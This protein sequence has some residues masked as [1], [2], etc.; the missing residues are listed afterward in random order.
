M[1]RSTRSLLSILKFLGKLQPQTELQLIAQQDE[2]FKVRVVAR[3]SAGLEGWTPQHQPFLSEDNLDFFLEPIGTGP[4]RWSSIDLNGN[5]VLDAF[6]S[7]HRGPPRIERVRRRR[8]SDKNTMI[9]RLVQEVLDLIP[10]T[11]F[12]DIA[13]IRGSGVCRTL[14]YPSLKFAGLAFNLQNPF[15]RQ[16]KARQAL[17]MA[18]DRQ[19][20][21][22]TY[23]QNQGTVIAG[24][25]SPHSWGYDFELEPASL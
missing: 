20:L 19:E 1:F 2:W 9:N 3:G 13:R 7:Y 8:S 10:E 23:Y 12:E 22:S 24:P 6:D 14:E 25:Y 18:V 21:L 4:Y 16:L 17:T 5:I 11:P 15:L